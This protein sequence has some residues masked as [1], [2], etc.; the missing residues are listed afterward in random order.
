[1]KYIAIIYLCLHTL[2]GYSWPIVSQTWNVSSLPH[3]LSIT[4]AKGVS[5]KT[6]GG[7]VYF[8]VSFDTLI[9]QYNLLECGGPTIGDTWDTTFILISSLDTPYYHLAVRE[10]WDTTSTHPYCFDTVGG[11]GQ[12]Y[13]GY[14]APLS[15]NQIQEASSG[16]SCYPNPVS[17]RLRVKGVSPG[18]RV[19]IGYLDG[20]IVWQGAYPAEGL[21]VHHW[22]EG[23]YLL[24]VHTEHPTRPLKW[25][26]KN[27]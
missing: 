18:T 1:M 6:T 27:E 19:S 15:S 16:L 14:N 13:I 8:N 5:T 10:V 25:I 17:E 9:A 2:V 20:R 7:K 24:W 12:V 22:R 3:T 23:M 26:K 4:V 11:M 21:P